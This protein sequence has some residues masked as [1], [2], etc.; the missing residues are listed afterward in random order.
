MIT[1]AF[2]S[3]ISERGQDNGS[4]NI[5]LRK[6]T[7]NAQQLA[8]VARAKAGYVIIYN[9]FAH[10]LVQNIFSILDEFEK[11]KQNY[12]DS[13]AAG[14]SNSQNKLRDRRKKRG[15]K[16]VDDNPGGAATLETVVDAFLTDPVNFKASS[17]TNPKRNATDNAIA[18]AVID[19]EMME[20]GHKSA[21][22]D[23]KNR[24]REKEQ[25]LVLCR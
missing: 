11:A 15:E 24:H 6:K 10:I 25:S 8:D 12:E 14:K 7:S 19:R 22:E 18:F 3:Q 4:D 23:I 1:E 21:T 16:D 20:K 17:V 2:D 13:L 5:Y 9:T